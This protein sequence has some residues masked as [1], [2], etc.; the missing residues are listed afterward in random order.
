ML[1]K[2]MGGASNLPV[3]VHVL[4]KGFARSSPTPL[5]FSYG[6]YINSVRSKGRPDESASGSIHGGDVITLQLSGTLLNYHP[7]AEKMRA[8]AQTPETYLMDKGVPHG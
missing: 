7:Y 2:P 5:T 1:F 4:G 8:A 6:L 3:H